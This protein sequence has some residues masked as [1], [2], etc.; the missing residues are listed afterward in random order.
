MAEYRLDYEFIKDRYDSELARKDKLSDSLGLPI[1]V[2]IVLGG[3]AVTMLQGFSRSNRILTMIFFAIIV[4]GAV[5]FVRCLWYFAKAYHG[6]TY[7]QLPKMN[8]MYKVLQQYG[9]YYEESGGD[10]QQAES[11]FEDNLR[12]RMIEAVDQNLTSN[13]KRLEFL[14]EGIVWLFVLLVGTAAAA[15]PYTIDRVVAPENIPVVHIDN[16]DATR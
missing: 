15:V 16:L 4:I 9:E 6:Q 13:N 7:S 3:L 1:S 14:H 5:A 10:E 2:L 8:D 11:D 12:F